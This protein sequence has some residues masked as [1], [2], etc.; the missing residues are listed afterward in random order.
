[1]Y[2]R[3]KDHLTH[4]FGGGG[5]RF[6]AFE[7]LETQ[8]CR[9]EELGLRAGKDWGL[10]LRVKDLKGDTVSVGIMEVQGFAG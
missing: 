9:I 5:W 8:G 6:K 1:M 4:A 10:G 3:I 7:G 2:I